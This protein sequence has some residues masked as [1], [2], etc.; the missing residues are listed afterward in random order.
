MSQRTESALADELVQM[1]VSMDGDVDEWIHESDKLAK[2]TVHQ[3]A[4]FACNV[5]PTA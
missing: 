4:S 3:Y 2:D 1:H 5:G